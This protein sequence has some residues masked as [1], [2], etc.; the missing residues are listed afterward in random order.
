M[1]SVGCF[2]R[3]GAGVAAGSLRGIHRLVDGGWASTCCF[4]VGAEDISDRAREVAPDVS[5]LPALDV[6]VVRMQPA[7]EVLM[8]VVRHLGFD[9]PWLGC[10][11]C[12]QGVNSRFL[13]RKM[14]RRR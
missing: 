1:L 11:V 8:M 10:K 3:Q 13:R 5:K 2:R 4:R 12:V 9:V 7:V 14:R 6:V